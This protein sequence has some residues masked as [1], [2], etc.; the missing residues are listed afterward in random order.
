M[1]HSQHQSVMFTHGSFA[2]HQ[3]YRLYCNGTNYPPNGCSKIQS[4]Q[5]YDELVRNLGIKFMQNHANPFCRPLMRRQWVNS[6]IGN[7]KKFGRGQFGFDFDIECAIQLHSTEC[8]VQLCMVE[9]V[10]L[11][12]SNFQAYITSIECII[13]SVFKFS[14]ARS[15]NF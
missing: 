2:T 9:H 7:L 15:S 12:C 5:F 3:C 13:F 6:E 10:N 14:V 4:N 1:Q 8:F 11:I